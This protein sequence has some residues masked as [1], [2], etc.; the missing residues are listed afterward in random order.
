MEAEFTHRPRLV[1]WELTKGCNLRCIHC[2]ASATELCSPEDLPTLECVRIIDELAEYA[3]LILVLS[4]GEPLYRADVFELARHATQRGLRV[5]LATNG[6][7]VD[8]SIARQIRDSGVV[9][10]AVSL[11]GPD[12]PTHDAF[13]GIPGA[14]DRAINGLRLIQQAGISVQI[15]TT[16]A[17]HNAARLSETLALARRLGVDAFHLFLLV[18]VG[19]GVEIVE[20]QM[21]EAREYKRILNWLYEQMYGERMELKATCSPHFFRVVRQRRA[22]LRRRGEPLPELPAME[23]R[24]GSAAGPALNAMTRGCLAGSGVCFISHQG[25]VYPCGYLPVEAGD[26]RTQQFTEVWEGSPLFASLQDVEKLQGKCGVCEFSRVCTGCRARAYGYSG[27][28]FA[29]EPFCAYE[30]AGHY[31]RRTDSGRAVQENASFEV[32][33]AV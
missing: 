30:P 22:S 28:F 25:Q 5:A 6:T 18:P 33:V 32:A 12:A 17:R 31:R 4:G 19:C 26:L 27:D 2:R 29:E 14:F 23:H 13:R 9:R 15:N 21:V 11:D 20:R 7:L 24:H 3:P 16:V 1:F 8:E 10:V